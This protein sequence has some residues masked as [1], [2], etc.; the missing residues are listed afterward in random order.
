MDISEI[1]LQGQ[2]KPNAEPPCTA[3][4]VILRGYLSSLFTRKDTFFLPSRTTERMFFANQRTMTAHFITSLDSLSIV[5]TNS[6]LKKR[7]AKR[8]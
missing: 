1:C 6:M 4:K 3:W 5:T 2:R 8:H 7:G